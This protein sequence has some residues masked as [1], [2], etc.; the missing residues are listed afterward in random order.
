MQARD[1]L[2]A[3]HNAC[4]AL[5][6]TA[7]TKAAQ[8][9]VTKALEKL[10]KTAAQPLKDGQPAAATAAAAQPAEDPA[11]PSQPAAQ[12]VG[13]QGCSEQPAGQVLEEPVAMEVDRPEGEANRSSTLAPA[14]VGLA[15]AWQAGLVSGAAVWRCHMRGLMH[16][17]AVRCCPRSS[18][19]LLSQMGF[20]CMPRSQAWQ[21][22]PD[23]AQEW[24]LHSHMARW[25][26]PDSQ[27]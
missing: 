12:A 20:S 3:L 23:R 17:W 6:S 22:G 14:Q 13:S 9:K 21:S 27:A 5:R 25:S 2:T 15:Q 8:N 7:T 26:Q 4:T 11:G 10:A 1:R 18:S 19:L 16:A 24:H